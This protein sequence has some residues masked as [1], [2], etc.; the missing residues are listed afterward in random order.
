[1]K[2]MVLGLSLALATLVFL[3]SP[4]MAADPP[5]AARTLSA[6]DHAFLTSLA[7]QVETPDPVPAAKRP[8]GIGQK[9]LC[10]ATAN[11]GNG[12]TVSCQGNNSTTSCSATDGNCTTGQ[13][14]SVTCDGVTTWC[15]PPEPCPCGPNF[16]TDQDEYNC[17]IGCSPCNYTFTCNT[18]YCFERCRCH[19]S[20]CP[21]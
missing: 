10:G 5:Q 14:G 17:A 7:R 20:T 9:A 13:Q 18:T 3:V 8:S 16:C 11:C 19:W 2:K 15:A 21:V 6:A 4:A 1:M 12:N